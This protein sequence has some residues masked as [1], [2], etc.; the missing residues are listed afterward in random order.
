VSSA[1]EAHGIP[2]LP[3]KGVLTAHLLYEDVASRPISD[4]D[5]RIPPRCFRQ[6]VRVA[7]EQ[8]WSL[9]TLC[10]TLWTAIMKVDGWEVD[11]EGALGL[12]GLCTLSVEDVMRRARRAVEPLGFTHLQ[13]ELHDH[14]LILVLNAFKDGL[15][16]MPWAIEDLR[17]VAKHPTFDPG[18]LVERAR[19]GRV[20]SALWIVAD[21]LYRDHGSTEWRTIRDRVGARPPSTRVGWAYALAQRLDWPPKAGL[22]ATAAGSDALAGCASGVALAAAGILR[23][24]A[25]RV[26]RVN[27]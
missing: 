3:V 12:P 15:R 1:L 25:L 16:P 10:P 6:A 13:P 26:L 22:L 14:T 9:N 8:G 20:A 24:R 4:I 5:L 21:W 27:G 2:I 18:M 11:L 7:R 17:R 23:G 19:D